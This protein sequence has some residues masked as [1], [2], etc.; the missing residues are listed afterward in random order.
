MVLPYASVVARVLPL[1][2][3]GEQGLD[4]GPVDV[5]LGSIIFYFKKLIF[6]VG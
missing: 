1:C 5:D 4:L 3:S 6:Y 2:N